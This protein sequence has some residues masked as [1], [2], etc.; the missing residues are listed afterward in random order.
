[1][2]KYIYENL[3]YDLIGIFYEVYNCLGHGYKER[4]YCNAIMKLLRKNN[5]DFA[6]QFKVPV[7]IRDEI[8]CKRYLDFLIDD[9][10]IVEIKVGNKSSGRDF[11]QIKEYLN[12]S[13]YKLGLLVLFRDKDVKIYRIANLYKTEIRII[14]SRSVDLV[15]TLCK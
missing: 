8:V 2:T 15:V 4:T 11:K 7:K 14:C 12:L 3:T 10:V 9:K 6:Y 13:G 5:L 1:M